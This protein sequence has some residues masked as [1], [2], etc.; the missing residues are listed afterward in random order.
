[1]PERLFSTEALPSASDLFEAFRKSE[2]RKMVEAFA[3]EVQSHYPRKIHQENYAAALSRWL[4]YFALAQLLPPGT[5]LLDQPATAKYYFDV[6][7][8]ETELVQNQQDPFRNSLMQSA[9]GSAEEYRLPFGVLVDDETGRARAVIEGTIAKHTRKIQEHDLLKAE[10]PD[11]FS[12]SQLVFAITSGSNATVA[13]YLD[14]T[15]GIQVILLPYDKSVEQAFVGG[16]VKQ[17]LS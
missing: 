11:L 6:V 2:I 4:K 17:L 10:I 3:Y 7:P 8:G 5:M 15:P 12:D 16:L 13:E 9:N 1:M 14:R